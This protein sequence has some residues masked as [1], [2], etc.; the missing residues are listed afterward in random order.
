MSK[1]LLLSKEN[2]HSLIV[3]EFL[4]NA[5]G[6]DAVS[7]RTSNQ[8]Y[9]KFP[10]ELLDYKGK[11]LI[12]FLSPWIVPK[13]VISNYDI[14]INFH[15]G[16]P[17]YPGT[18]CYNF[19]LY[20]E[21]VEY[22]VT[23]HKMTSKVDAGEILQVIRFPVYKT[24]SVKSLK[25]RSMVYMTKLFFEIMEKI[26]NGVEL[27]PT[28]EVWKREAYTRKD[29]EKLCKIN[30]ETSSEEISRVI[31]ATYYPGMP[32]AYMKINGFKFEFVPKD[33]EK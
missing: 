33:N 30:P 21:V 5:Y 26:L 15:P 31:R 20:D 17:E 11:L 4:L 13:K 12:S 2:P 16:P 29:L 22:G 1:V 10:K 25:E 32:G 23:C 27:K 18:G 9:Q 19:A 7:Y 28:K 14:A 3:K 6:K 8:K 24:D